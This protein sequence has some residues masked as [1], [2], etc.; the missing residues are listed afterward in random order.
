M[1]KVSIIALLLFSSC[2]ENID[3]KFQEKNRLSIFVA[4]SGKMA[5]TKVVD[6]FQKTHKDIKVDIYS[7]SSGKGFAQLLNGFQ[8]DLYFSAD[9]EYPTKVF[10]QN[11]STAPKIYAIGLLALYS[12]N[13]EL[14]KYGVEGMIDSRVKIVSIANPRLAPYGLL[15]MEVLSSYKIYEK[16]YEKIVK[17]DNIAQSLQFIDTGSADIGIV[18]LSLLEDRPK[19]E[20]ILIDKDRYTPVKQAFVITKFGDK[21][22]LAKEFSDFIL[23]EKGQSI[24][25]NSGFGIELIQDRKHI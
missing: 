13:S 21:K 15:A 18:A 3:A 16:V 12:K 17:G 4:S 8:Y 14:L 11:L 10:E 23:S 25:Q 5:I 1:W 24:I 20:Y 7:M 19:S 2:S 9:S 6:T 22:D